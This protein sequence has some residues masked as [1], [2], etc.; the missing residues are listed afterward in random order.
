MHK[1]K[2]FKCGRF[3]Q[4]E[5]TFFDWFDLPFDIR[6]RKQSVKAINIEKKEGTSW[7]RDSLFNKVKLNELQLFDELDEFEVFF[8]GT[9]H[10]NATAIIDG[11]D[12][13]KGGQKMEF[14]HGD[15]FYVFNNLFDA[16]HWAASSFSDYHSA[17]LVFRLTK[18]ELR[19][20]TITMVWI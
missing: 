6:S 1:E 4:E 3:A 11:I 16:R 18:M 8:H 14:S 10:E 20:I 13:K 7:K 12:F 17:V 15:N 2:F 9:S 5:S 19:G